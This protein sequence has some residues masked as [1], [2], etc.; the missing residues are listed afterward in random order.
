M[1]VLCLKS[2]LAKKQNKKKRKE[3]PLQITTICACGPPQPNSPLDNTSLALRHLHGVFKAAHLGSGC[4]TCRD[5]GPPS[6]QPWRCHPDC[7]FWPVFNHQTNPDGGLRVLRPLVA[8]EAQP[9]FSF[10]ASSLDSIDA[11]QKRACGQN[12]RACIRTLMHTRTAHSHDEID[13]C[14][15]TLALD[16]L[17]FNYR[18]YD[19]ALNFV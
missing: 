11:R 16:V 6:Q 13:S 3:N 12:W 4:L 19:H 14:S 1:F 18:H 2:P 15:H 5:G 10:S 17:P 8:K 7:F 9:F